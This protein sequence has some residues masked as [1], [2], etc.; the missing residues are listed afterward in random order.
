MHAYERILTFQKK[1]SFQ[2][3]KTNKTKQKKP[4]THETK[5]NKK[6]IGNIT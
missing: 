3:T 2:F 1:A 5:A 6:V 4:F